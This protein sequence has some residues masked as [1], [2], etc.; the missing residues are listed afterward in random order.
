[1]AY[2]HLGHNCEVGDNVVIANNVQV[3]GHVVVEDKLLLEV[4]WG[5]INL[6]I[7]VI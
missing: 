6:F 7:S 2:S 5:Y 3:A 1:M 4:V